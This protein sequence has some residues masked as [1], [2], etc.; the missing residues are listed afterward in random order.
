MIQLQMAKRTID[1]VPA[2]RQETSEEGLGWS[3]LL[4]D[5]SDTLSSAG[6]CSSRGVVA[7]TIAARKER[8]TTQGL[9]KWKMR[10]A[11]SLELA[12]W[13]EP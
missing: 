9:L 13:R 10:I 3:T 1:A 11:I 2:E 12:P 7:K 4:Q 8:Q 5:E 6:V